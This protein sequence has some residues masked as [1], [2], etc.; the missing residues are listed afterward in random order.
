MGGVGGVGAVG[1]EGMAMGV[2][3][4]MGMNSQ[5]QQQQQLPGAAAAMSQ[6]PGMPQMPMHMPMHMHIP[7][8]GV[9]GV[10]LAQQKAMQQQQLE[11]MLGSSRMQAH[12]Q[13]SNQLGASSRVAAPV[14]A[15]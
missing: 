3:M 6:L 8:A 7:S 13:Q 9:T 14:P 5:Q 15:E 11:A 1:Q 12:T 2:G 10:T 4:G